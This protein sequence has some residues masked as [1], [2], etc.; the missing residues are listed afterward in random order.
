MQKTH[1]LN[2][3]QMCLRSLSCYSIS[4]TALKIVN[5]L[6]GFFIS[7][8]M[9]TI[10]SQT[11]DWGIIAGAIAVTYIEL[12]SNWVYSNNL[13]NNK[14]MANLNSLRIGIIYGMFVDAFKLG[15]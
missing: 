12:F 8:V 14:L 11:G 13:L 7:T 1:L 10:V 9:T 3:F 5:L 15:S 6:I 2:R 4:Y